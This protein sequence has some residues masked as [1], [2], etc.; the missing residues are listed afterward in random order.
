M[1]GCP[2]QV[3]RHS[4]IAQWRALELD[5][6]LTPMLGPALDLNAPGKTTGEAGSPITSLSL[7]SSLLSSALC[8]VGLLGS[9]RRGALGEDSNPDRLAVRLA[10][11]MGVRW[12]ALGGNE[13]LVLSD[14]QVGGLV[15]ESMVFGRWCLKSRWDLDKPRK[16]Q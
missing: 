16:Q 5:V 6:L 9:R 1:C 8:L 3:Y 10:G 12:Y 7:V 11:E 14:I 13:L 15:T 4:V 2:P